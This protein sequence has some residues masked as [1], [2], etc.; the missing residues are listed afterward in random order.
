MF[1]NVG[2]VIVFERLTGKTFY[3][4]GYEYRELS[5]CDVLAKAYDGA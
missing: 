3:M 5:Q 1:F 2:D 4:G